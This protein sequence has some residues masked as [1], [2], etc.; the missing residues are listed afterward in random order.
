MVVGCPVLLYSPNS[1]HTYYLHVG[2]GLWWVCVQGSGHD[3]P[4][5]VSADVFKCLVLSETQRLIFLWCQKKKQQIFILE[6][7]EM[8][9][10]CYFCSEMT[11][12]LDWRLISCRSTNPPI[13]SALIQYQKFT[14]I[15]I[16]VGLKRFYF[17]VSSSGW[18]D[19]LCSTGRS[20]FP[21]TWRL[22]AAFTLMQDS[23][24]WLWRTNWEL[25]APPSTS[26]SS[27]L[28]CAHQRLT[29]SHRHQSPGF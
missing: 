1:V 20:I 28:V 23:T 9:N 6:T 4:S 16:Y 2:R 3:N 19:C 27:V 14:R 24:K 11:E 22:T 18:W 10:F 15:L 12:L 25:P 29:F 5:M 8:D 13:V 17:S 26:K 21:V 7:L